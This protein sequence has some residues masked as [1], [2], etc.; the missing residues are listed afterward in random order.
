MCCPSVL[1]FFLFFLLAGKPGRGAKTVC[2]LAELVLQYL[3]ISFACS[4]GVVV[5]KGRIFSR[6]T[7]LSSWGLGGGVEVEERAGWAEPLYDA[8]VT[9]HSQPVAGTGSGF[10]TWRIVG[11]YG[12]PV[13][14]K[15]MWS[16]GLWLV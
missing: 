5:R 3:C 9:R 14:E 7:E 11:H 8:K 12:G 6:L 16:T 2:C 1:L 13:I 10:H 15:T 4:F